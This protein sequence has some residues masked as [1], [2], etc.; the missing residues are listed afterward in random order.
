MIGPACTGETSCD[1]CF[2]QGISLACSCA[3]T[4]PTQ[5]PALPPAVCDKMFLHSPKSVFLHTSNQN[6]L[7][8]SSWIPTKVV[9]SVPTAPPERCSYAVVPPPPSLSE[10]MG[11]WGG[12]TSGDI[13]YL[14]Q[15]L[16]CDQLEYDDVQSLHFFHSPPQKSSSP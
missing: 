8:F 7:L 13:S 4:V 12:I 2:G 9:A 1:P 16:F 5:H 6:L 14:G 10:G 15:T 3:I 11:E